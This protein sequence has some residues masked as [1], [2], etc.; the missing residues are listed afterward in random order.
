MRVQPFLHAAGQVAGERRALNLVKCEAYYA[1]VLPRFR[2]GL[3]PYSDRTPIEKDFD[4]PAPVESLTCKRRTGGQ[5]DDVLVWSARKLGNP[6]V[7]RLF[8]QLEPGFER[9]LEPRETGGR[10]LY[11]RKGL[12][13]R[14]KGKP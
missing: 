2:P 6:T 14:A 3:D 9:V 1:Y 10:Q 13:P 8:H 11:R 4:R 7:T 5:M 12:Q